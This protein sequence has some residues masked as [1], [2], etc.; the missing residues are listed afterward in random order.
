[1]ATPIT[2]TRGALLLVGVLVGVVIALGS[3]LFWGE[4]D[5]DAPSSAA[6][7]GT[8]LERDDTA[9]PTGTPGEPDTEPAD[10]P[11]PATSSVSTPGGEPTTTPVT[12]D[13]PDTSDAEPTTTGERPEPTSPSPTSGS[14]SPTGEPTTGTV[15]STSPSE[16]DEDP[17]TELLRHVN[18]ERVAAGCE[19]ATTD[20][21]LSSA[22]QAHSDDMSENRRLSHE[23]SDGTTFEERVESF[24]YDDPAAENLAMGVTSPRA[25]VDNWMAQPAHNANITDCAVTAIAPASTPTAGTGP[26]TSA[27]EA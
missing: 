13:S 25:V 22:G 23:S 21:A 27:T 20:D 6:G 9:A 19:P 18:D 16:P 11:G 15:T 1:M 12:S 24:G 2:R 4:S 3:H 10:P 7:P 17:L 26:S 8:S 14:T 5:P